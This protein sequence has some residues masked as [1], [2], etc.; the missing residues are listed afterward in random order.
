M[1][2]SPAMKTYVQFDVTG[3]I[4]SVVTVDAPEGVRAMVDVD[5][6]LAVVEIDAAQFKAAT[7]DVEV[8]KLRTLIQ[9]YRVSVPAAAKATL[10]KAK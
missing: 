5:P 6:G 7:T 4:H 10:T 3:R 8:D 1:N 2:R 9:D